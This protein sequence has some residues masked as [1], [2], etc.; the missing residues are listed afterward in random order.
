MRY[1]SNVCKKNGSRGSM[2]THSKHIHVLCKQG[3]DVLILY[4]N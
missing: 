3:I 2:I 4:L 1:E